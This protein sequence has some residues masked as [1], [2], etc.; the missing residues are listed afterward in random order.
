[1]TPEQKSALLGYLDDAKAKVAELPKRIEAE[2][3]T[4]ADEER[5]PFPVIPLTEMEPAALKDALESLA[6]VPAELQETVGV[7][8]KVCRRQ[9]DAFCAPSQQVLAVLSL[10][11]GAPQPEKG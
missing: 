7:W 6:S 2:K 8:R 3:V 5:K 11:V 9:K 1:M 10:L 4:A